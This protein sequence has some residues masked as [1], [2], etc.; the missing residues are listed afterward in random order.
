MNAKRN[1]YSKKKYNTDLSEY[2]NDDPKLCSMIDSLQCDLANGFT[3]FTKRNFLRFIHGYKEIDDFG[4]QFVKLND[5]YSKNNKYSNT[6]ELYKILYGET[7]GSKRWELK[8]SKVKGAKNPGYKHGG[9]LSPWS[10]KSHFY[11]EESKQKALNRSYNTK[12]SYWID[13][14]NGDELLAKHMLIERQKTFSLNKCIEKYGES[15]G[16]D[17]WR[18]RQIKWQ[19]TLNNKTA[20]EID[21]INARKSSGIAH[22]PDNVPV[23]LYYIRFYND[24]IEFWKIG[25]TYK[26]INKRFNLETLYARTGLKYEII[27]VKEHENRHNAYKYEQLHLN[28]FSDYRIT[29]DYNGFKTT[30]AFNTD[31]LGLLE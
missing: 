25:I 29:I 12:L 18:K 11:S 5:Y 4:N 24:D 2:K 21:S 20:E 22:I 8:K 26:E 17:I 19:R 14:T 16:T 23:K 7:E 1:F 27:R 15:K 6:E 31:I 3:L 30:E 10:K 28:E 9:K 13:K